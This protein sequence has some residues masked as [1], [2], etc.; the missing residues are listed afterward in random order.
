MSTDIVKLLL[1]KSKT[2]CRNVVPVPAPEN[3]TPKCEDS[4]RFAIWQLNENYI[5]NSERVHKCE[6]GNV[7][8]K[9]I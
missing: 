2:S 1:V 7:A 9:S 3:N 8:M 6:K 4:I 5:L